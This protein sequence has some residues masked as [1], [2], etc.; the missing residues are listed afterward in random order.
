VPTACARGLL[1]DLHPVLVSRPCR[2]AIAKPHALVAQPDRASDF[3]SEGREFESLRAHHTEMSAKNLNPKARFQAQTSAWVTT[4]SPSIAKCG[5]SWVLHNRVVGFLRYTMSTDFG[6][7]AFREAP[8]DS[9][10]SRRAS[11]PAAA[12]RPRR[13]DRPWLGLRRSQSPSRFSPMRRHAD[14]TP[15]KTPH[16]KLYE[17]A[18]EA[19]APSCGGPC[20][21]PVGIAAQQ[22]I[23]LFPLVHLLGFQDDSA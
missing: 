10:P 7:R 3:E 4:G 19:W 15:A 9:G 1:R 22:V 17:C 21:S 20:R 12:N 14:G 23:V 16:Q 2:Q 13:C 8:A 18:S 11:P 5:R 6:G